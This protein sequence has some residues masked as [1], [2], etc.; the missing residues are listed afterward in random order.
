MVGVDHAVYIYDNSGAFSDINSLKPVTDLFPGFAT[1][2]NWPAKLC[3]NRPGN[4][5]NKGERSSQYAAA[6]SSH[7]RFGAHS[8]WLM[9]A[10]TDE[11]TAPMGTNFKNLQV[12]LSRVEEKQGI[13]VLNWKSKRS[14]PWLQYFKCANVNIVSICNVILYS[15]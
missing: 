14:K 11:Y 1:R 6:M 3:N 4:G 13:N 15:F 7:L 8:D 9:A 12:L 10:D 5:D 2:L